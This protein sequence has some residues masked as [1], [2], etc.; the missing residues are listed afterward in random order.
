MKRRDFL[1]G[2][3]AAGLA[4]GGAGVGRGA[5]GEGGK[6]LL[7]LR[8]YH[9]ATPAKQAAFDAFL[10]ATAIPA[11]NRI[12]IQPVGVFKQL[13]ADNP[14]LKMAAD[15]TDLYVLIPYNSAEAFV[16]MLGRLIEEGSIAQGDESILAPPKDDPAYQDFESSLL[17][18]FD[19]APKVEAPTKAETRLMQLRIYQSHSD[20]RALKKIQMFN[21]G[22]EIA[23][24]RRVGMTPVFFG[25][26]LTGSNLPHLTYMLGFESPAAQKKAWDAFRQ[27]AG[28]KTLSKD[29][30]YADTV[31]KI[32]NIILRPAKSSQI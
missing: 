11:L 19:E 23:L 13:Q 20:E 28:W 4:F 5:E 26:A 25:Q 30:E 9:F 3:A 2:S 7:E 22:G 17:L 1:A 15:G 29:P 24:F 8:I 32:T 21:Q 31:S 6:Q 10:G 18:A 12:G 14:E 16:S 27:D